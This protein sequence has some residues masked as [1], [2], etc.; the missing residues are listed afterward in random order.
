MRKKF[1]ND[2]M[3]LYIFAVIFFTVLCLLPG[4]ATDTRANVSDN[5]IGTADYRAVQTQQREGETELAVTG[6]KLEFESKEIRAELNR[7]EQS[8][9]A[10]KGAEQE[11]GAIIQQVRT[12]EVAPAFIEEWRNRAA[13]ERSG[14]NGKDCGG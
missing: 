5:G 14:A 1:I 4:C 2:F 3:R 6:A 9:I 12:R 11:L 13:E 10:S 8:I 7:L